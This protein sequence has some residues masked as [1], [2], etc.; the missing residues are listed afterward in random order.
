MNY[1]KAVHAI[2][3][4]TFLGLPIPAWGQG[5]LENPQPQASESGV[6]VVSGWHCDADVIEIQFDD[7]ARLEAAYG[8]SR[9]D[10]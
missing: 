7:L 9:G 5:V 3:I 4:W 6:G 1:Y 8:T 10:M 2:T